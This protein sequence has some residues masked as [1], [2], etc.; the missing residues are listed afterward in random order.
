MISCHHIA[1][2]KVVL[3]VTLKRPLEGSEGGRRTS[4][5]VDGIEILACTERALFDEMGIYGIG[6]IAVA[7]GARVAVVAARIDEQLL[8]KDP[9]Q[10]VRLP[11][12]VA[13]LGRFA[14]GAHLGRMPLLEAAVA[15]RR[16]VVVFRLR[17]AQRP[18]RFR[19]RAA[20]VP[21]TG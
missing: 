10:V 5:Q 20:L 4:L 16:V 1:V 8:R 3:A 13:P 11:A 2:T 21:V 9:L 18:R 15:G 19:Q 17:T 12:L 14:L 6:P 7:L